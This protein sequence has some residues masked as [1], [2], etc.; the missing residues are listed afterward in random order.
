MKRIPYSQTIYRSINAIYKILLLIIDEI[1]YL[2]V[3]KA[4][5]LWS[6]DNNAIIPEITDEPEIN[7]INAYHPYLNHVLTTHNKKIVPLT[8]NLTQN[9]RFLIISGPNAG[10]K[11]VVLL[12][13]ATMHG[14]FNVLY[15]SQ[16]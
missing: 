5:Y 11:S 14:W 16:L 4:K 10:G 3:L 13:V 1:T 6:T 9:N 12:T 8:I 7:L 2:D 15:L